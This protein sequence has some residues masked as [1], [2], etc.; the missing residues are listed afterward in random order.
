AK[1]NYAPYFLTVRDIVREAK[2]LDILAQGRGSAA[3]SAVCYVTGIT[4]VDPAKVDLLFERFISSE[5]GEPPDIDVD[6]EHERRA[7]GIQYSYRKYGRDRAALAATVICYRSKMAVRDVGKAMGLSVDTVDTLS[8]S[9]W[10]W[11]EVGVAETHAAE[12]GLDPTD[13]VMASVLA[14]T[15]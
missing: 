1:L 15:R 4:N 2:A 3:N 8:K 7:G 6:F 9:V 11:S 10:G 13:P 5:R 12:A 14:L